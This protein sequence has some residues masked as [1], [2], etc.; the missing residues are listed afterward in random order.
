[1]SLQLIGHWIRHKLHSVNVATGCHSNGWFRCGD[2][3]CVPRTMLC[4]GT[5]DC[6]DRT[7]EVTDCGE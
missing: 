4:D 7:D 3:H 1:M 6:G 5:D 2:G